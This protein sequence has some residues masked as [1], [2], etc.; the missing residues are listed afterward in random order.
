MSSLIKGTKSQGLFSVGLKYK[1]ILISWIKIW[2]TVVISPINYPKPLI[3]IMSL[4]TIG[5]TVLK[6]KKKKKIPH[7]V[8][9]ISKRAVHLGGSPL[10]CLGRLQNSHREGAARPE[11]GSSEQLPEAF[12]IS[13]GVTPSLSL[14]LFFLCL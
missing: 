11:T 13:Y 2:D 1:Y 4:I 7:Y 12:R 9:S 6:S 3:T 8:I 14:S 5:D 10:H